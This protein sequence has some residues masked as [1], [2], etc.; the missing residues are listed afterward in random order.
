MISRLT[1]RLTLTSCHKRNKNAP[2][3]STLASQASTVTPRLT[4]LM[5]LFGV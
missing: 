5:P 1:S 4:G 2:D 3:T